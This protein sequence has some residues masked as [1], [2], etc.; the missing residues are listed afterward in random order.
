MPFILGGRAYIEFT[1]GG[2]LLDNRWETKEI[3]DVFFF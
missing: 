1:E 3:R 2:K